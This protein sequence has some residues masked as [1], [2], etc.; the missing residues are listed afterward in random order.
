[1]TLIS[2][3]TIRDR[4]DRGSSGI[5]ESLD[6]ESTVFENCALSLTTNHANR[7][8]IQN[9]RLTN[10]TAHGCEVG[11]A[12]LTDV[13]IDTLT[14]SGLLVIWG[15]LFQRVAIRGRIGRIRINHWIHPTVRA[16]EV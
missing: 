9:V 1:M 14:T 8:C 11:P 15:A 6:V 10:C 16:T 5:I 4:I 3:V 2:G 13:V 12:R 7:T